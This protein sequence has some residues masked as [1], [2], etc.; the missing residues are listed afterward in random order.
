[1]SKIYHRVWKYNFRISG[2]AERSPRFDNPKSCRRM[3]NQN[4]LQLVTDSKV[5]FAVKLGNDG[6]KFKFFEHPSFFEFNF[7]LHVKIDEQCLIGL[8]RSDFSLFHSLGSTEASKNPWI[9]RI[10]FP[11]STAIIKHSIFAVF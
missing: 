2:A 4:T 9:L 5:N 1:M 10:F 6:K 3:K 11:N 7:Q 8:L